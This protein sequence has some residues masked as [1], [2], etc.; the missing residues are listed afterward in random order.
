MIKSYPPAS[1]FTR[2]M[3]V[4]RACLFFGLLSGS[5]I[6]FG[7]WL[8]P[9]AIYFKQA[10]FI[11]WMNRTYLRMAHP[12]FGIKFEITGKEHLSK[13]NTVMVCNHQSWMDITT[14]MI[15]VKFPSFLAK[16]EIERWPYFGGAMKV[17]NCV[18]VDRDDR[19]SR[20]KVALEIREKLGQGA[21]FCIFPEG[22]R[23]PDGRLGSFAGGAFRIAVD[24]DAL[25]TP[26][27]ID[28]SWWILNKKGFA[29]YPG[30]VRVRVLPPID[31]SL[32]EN[33][34]Y[35][36]LTQRVHDQMA[37]ALEEMRREPGASGFAR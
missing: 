34:D 37:V 15:E 3:A 12:L 27:V 6:F 4:F 21:D 9:A 33:R 14:V 2:A 22:T 19:R 17:L 32:P 23:S 5:I 8:I 13:R 30:T 18:F 20:T 26:V 29:L 1:R 28:E 35:K 10:A 31:T 7:F 36:E 25:V 24:A 16:K 11:R